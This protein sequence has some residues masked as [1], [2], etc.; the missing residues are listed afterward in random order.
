MEVC[1]CDLSEIADLRDLYR[2]RMN[3]QIVHD[4]IHRRP[5]WTL[6]YLLSENDKPFGYGSV[7]IEGPWKERHTLY[8][9]FVTPAY[10]TRTFEAFEALL[11]VCEATAIETQSNDPIL[12]P[13]LH[14]YAHNVQAEAILFEDSATTHLSPAGATW[15]ELNLDEGEVLVNDEAAG[16][17]GILW[18]YNPP[19][20]DLWMEVAEPNRR[21]GLGAYVVQQLK[22]QC[23][24]RGGIPAARCNIANAASRRTLQKAGFT[25]CGNIVSGD[26]AFPSV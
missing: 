18:H 17:G 10:C 8:E 3:C 12:T 24:A 15:R 6:E 2:Q 19:Y 14:T 26:L 22:T 23:R 11:A 4:S 16:K 25:P 13:L 7:A 21:K 9:F 20:G 5:G 1:R